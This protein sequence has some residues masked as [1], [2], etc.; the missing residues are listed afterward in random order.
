MYFVERFSRVCSICS[1]EIYI[2][3]ILYYV[4]TR[5]YNVYL[6][7]EKRYDL[8]AFYSWLLS[9]SR[10]FRPTVR[11]TRVTLS[12]DHMLIIDFDFQ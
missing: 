12:E 6:E 10:K 4:L 11:G 5:K 3:T 9:Q 7:I 8:Q 1:K 2:Y